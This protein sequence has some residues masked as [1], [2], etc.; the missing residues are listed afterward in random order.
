M[1]AGSLQI[2]KV[3]GPPQ[4]LCSDYIT[5]QELDQMSKE[6]AMSGRFYSEF[7]KPPPSNNKFNIAAINAMSGLCG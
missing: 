1:R 2:Q 6:L 7:N 5:D 3:D 4:I